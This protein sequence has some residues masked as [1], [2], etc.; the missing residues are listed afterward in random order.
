MLKLFIMCLVL[1]L[2]G[3]TDKGK[4]YKEGVNDMAELCKGKISVELARSH[5]NDSIT[6]RCD[7]MNFKSFA[8]E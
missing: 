2:V 5:W 1:G 6:F 7:D 8:K 4:A 3:C